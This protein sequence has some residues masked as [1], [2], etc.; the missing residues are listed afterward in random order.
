MDRGES[1][2]AHVERM[3][4]ELKSVARRHVWACIMEAC[5]MVCMA[6]GKKKKKTRNEMTITLG[7]REVG[8][9]SNP[10][11]QGM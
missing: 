9:V 8:N 10:S 11:V 1:G 4:A 3:R 7:R 6:R 5:S 2:S